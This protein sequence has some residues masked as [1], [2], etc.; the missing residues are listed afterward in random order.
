MLKRGFERGHLFIIGKSTTTGQDNTTIWASGGVTNLV[1]VSGGF[2]G[3]F[4][5]C[6][7]STLC[8]DYH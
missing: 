6:F 1:G 8:L 7:S 4:S 5:Q 2:S 3:G